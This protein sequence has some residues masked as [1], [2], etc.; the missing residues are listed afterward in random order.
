[1]MPVAPLVS[2]GSKNILICLMLVAAR[3]G[4]GSRACVCVDLA[5]LLSLSTS[6]ARRQKETA[7]QRIL[8][9][10]RICVFLRRV[11]RFLPGSPWVP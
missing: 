6:I 8:A 2:F 10:E 5:G 3:L 4:P 7:R 9:P 11:G 1:M